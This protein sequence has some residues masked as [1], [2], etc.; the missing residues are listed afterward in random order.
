MFYVTVNGTVLEKFQ[1]QELIK[2]QRIISKYVL[3][4]AMFWYILNAN[5]W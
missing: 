4:Q 3:T 5:S 1:S 2:N